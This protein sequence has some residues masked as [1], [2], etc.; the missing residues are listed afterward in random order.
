VQHH[1]SPATIR[2]T[3]RVLSSGTWFLTAGVVFY[4][5]MTTTPFVAGHSAWSWSGWVLGL[6][7]DVA[8]VMALQAESVLA[9]L[10]VEGL[11]VWPGV[12]RWLTG[13]ASVFLNVW[14]S[15]SR[16]DPVGATVHL[17][18][19]ALLLVVAEVGPVYRRAMADAMAKA[20]ANTRTEQAN[21]P[22]EH[23]AFAPV[24]A[25]LSAASG[26]A[27]AA[28]VATVPA[29]VTEANEPAEQAAGEP[30]EANA[31]PGGRLSTEQA[32][33]VIEECWSNGLGVRLTARKA[34]RSPSTVAQAFARLE[35]ER[36]PQPIAG[37]L[38]IVK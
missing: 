32:R 14:E 27:E 17:I 28:P 35:K 25:A 33:K 26:A 13:A 37:Q 9:Q 38:K 31:E 8:F 2:R 29:Q 19:P 22:T 18:A 24:S 10:G 30:A 15:V 4:S 12:F 1:V 34:T 21:T 36:G 20:E 11:G 6:M 23:P 16:H 3:N 7:V 5:L